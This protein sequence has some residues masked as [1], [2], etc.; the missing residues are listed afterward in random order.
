MYQSAVVW[1]LECPRRS[2]GASHVVTE[3]VSFLLAVTRHSFWPPVS[4]SHASAC[5]SNTIGI[6]SASLHPDFD[7]SEL[8]AWAITEPARYVNR[9]R[10]MFLG[11]TIDERCAVVQFFGEL[12]LS[13]R[14]KSASSTRFSD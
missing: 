13:P 7:V 6:R 11:I 1:H 10:T 3:T 2:V 12:F 14:L 8:E 9:I 5:K 4:G